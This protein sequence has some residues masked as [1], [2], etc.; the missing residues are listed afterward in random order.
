MRVSLISIV[1]QP[2]IQNFKQ[3]ESK[4][5][6]KTQ[7]DSISFKGSGCNVASWYLNHKG[8]VS[9]FKGNDF[10]AECAFKTTT[11]F[12]RL[13]GENSL[14][15]IFSFEPLEGCYGSY[16][17]KDRKVA[18]NELLPCFNDL[19]SLTK[20][21]QSA[22]HFLLPDEKSTLHPAHTYVHEFAHA[23]HHRNLDRRHN[24]GV[25]IMLDLTTTQVPT[26]IGR[27]I[28][29]FKLGKYSL[30]KNGGMNE[31]MAERI[32]Q[33]ICNN[34][35]EDTWAE[36]RYIYT[37]YSN[38]F[39]R[40]WNYRYSSPQAYLD[41]FTQQIWNGDIEEAINVA[42]EAER[43]M[44]EIDAGRTP[45]IIDKLERVTQEVTQPMKEKGGILE[46]TEE[47]TQQAVTGVSK[48]F[49]RVTDILDERNKLRLK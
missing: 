17:F 40:K 45:A 39:D 24:N 30:D 38:I 42:E 25:D 28:T 43:Y 32:A 22:Y 1:A 46:K 33:D 6:F 10:V 4:T 3:I 36:K 9:D 14:P 11:L 44:K 23:A 41:Y 19:K 27:L 20:E 8:I 37:D 48:F 26:A 47:L 2:K 31:F 7:K 35:T 18:I 16:F 15:K 29:K 49:N 12:E 21:T 13:F 5:H 34:L